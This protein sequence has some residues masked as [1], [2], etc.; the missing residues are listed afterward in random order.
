VDRDAAHLVVRAGV[1]HDE[2]AGLLEVLL[3]LVGEGTGG[4]AA[5]EGLGAGVVSELEHSA[6]QKEKG[7]R[8]RVSTP[9]HLGHHEPWPAGARPR[10]Q[11]AH[12]RLVAVVR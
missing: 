10:V 8:G 2:E 7:G 11:Q 6:L 12:R 9:F 3:L 4:V 5:G 1:S